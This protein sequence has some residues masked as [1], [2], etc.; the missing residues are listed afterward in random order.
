[1]GEITGNKNKEREINDAVPIE[2]GP[3]EEDGPV[4]I[5]GLEGFNSE[6]VA[7]LLKVKQDI[8]GGR[9]SDITNEHRKLIFAK[10]LVSHGKLE[11]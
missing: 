4:E 10:W 7:R 1:M 5:D 9:Y 2:A 11:K 3:I 8:A 6:E